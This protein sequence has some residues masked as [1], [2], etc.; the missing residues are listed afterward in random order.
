MKKIMKFSALLCAMTL[1]VTACTREEVEP[2]FTPA[3]DGSEIQFGARAGFENGNPETRTVY[4]G[5]TYILDGK[6]FERIDW[7]NNDL[8]EIYCPE[9]KGLKSAQY[10]VT[11]QKVDDVVGGN[12]VYD[13]GYLS[14]LNEDAGALQWNGD[15]THTFYAM[16]PSSETL[17]GTVSLEPANGNYYINAVITNEQH[18]EGAVVTETGG[19]KHYEFKPDMRFAYMAAVGEAK[20]ADGNV[21]LNFKPIVTAI[22]VELRLPTEDEVKDTEDI[23]DVTIN[24]V[25]VMAVKLSGVGL[26]GKFSAN[27]S[28]WSNGYPAITAGEVA[29]EQSITSLLRDNEGNLIT[30]QEGESLAFTIFVCPTQEINLADLTVGFSPDGQN[31]KTKGL[32]ATASVAT[33][34]PLKKTSLKG[35]KLPYTK[36]SFS[37]A[38]WMESVKDEATIL[39]LSLPGTGGSFSYGYTGSN[40]AY[41][42]QQ[43][44]P[45]FT[46][47]AGYEG[48]TGQWEMGIRAFEMA[49][50]RPNGSTVDNAGSLDGQPIRVN[51]QS[52]GS[53]TVGSAVRKLLDKISGSDETAMVIITY[54]PEGGT[55]LN[56]HA[57]IFAQALANFYDE[58]MDETDAEGNLKYKDKIILYTPQTKMYDAS[59][60]AISARGKLMIVARISQRDEQ[61]H[62]DGSG[63]NTN[64]SS[65][66]FWDTDYASATSN[67]GRAKSYYTTNNIPILLVNGCGS[68]KDRW[69]ARGY[70]ISADGVTW[71]PAPDMATAVPGFND[72]GLGNSVEAYMLG[73]CMTEGE[74][75]GTILG[76]IPQYGVIRQWREFPTW[77]VRA[78]EGGQYGFATSNGAQMVWYQDWSRVVDLDYIKQQGGDV[79][80]VDGDGVADFYERGSYPGAGNGITT[81]NNG[82]RWR[83]SYTEK[84]ADAKATFDLAISKSASYANYVFINSLCGYLVDPG[85]SRSYKM[86]APTGT[87]ESGSARYDWW[88][89]L[90]GNIEALATRI[91]GEFGAYVLDVISAQGDRGATGVVMMDRLSDQTSAGASNYLPSV[92]ITNNLYSGVLKNSNTG[93]E[94]PEEPET[95]V[96]PPDTPG[97]GDEEEGM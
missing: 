67:W 25:R 71:A 97:P 82:I 61:E 91:N 36:I 57:Y 81:N 88:G 3:L 30:L 38:N 77:N 46:G 96:T 14:K 89:G 52:M 37:Y 1:L 45:I 68:A 63:I 64:G 16:Y 94:E 60:D 21:K 40:A 86:F 55:G 73:Q 31:F 58:L 23:T 29:E 34:K 2:N 22:R 8:V 56:R 47:E 9:A 15:G 72:A 44:L 69:Q 4:S 54:Q 95:P 35:L 53:W 92:I 33:I 28:S 43:T 48:L 84:L 39:E 26:V 59:N 32:Q 93:S 6:T 90:E 27:L 49:C 41:Y 75:T 50:D 76:F 51:G 83:E 18:S 7:V 78:A 70:E 11:S 10:A 17:G 65:N 19:K 74:Q 12:D 5:E 42:K 79:V 80:D 24:P 62:V 66:K 13:E 20:A 87:Y 85:I